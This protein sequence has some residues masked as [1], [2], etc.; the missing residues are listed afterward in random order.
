LGF[1]IVG[2]ENIILRDIAHKIRK[3][4]AEFYMF[5]DALVRSGKEVEERKMLLII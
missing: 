5:C 1:L 2:K 3:R 4:L